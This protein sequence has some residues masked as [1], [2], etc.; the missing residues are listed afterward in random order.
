MI[1]QD[2]AFDAKNGVVLKQ[3]GEPRVGVFHGVAHPSTVDDGAVHQGSLYVR[4]NGELYQKT[5]TA[6]TTW[7]LKSS[8]AGSVDEQ[9]RTSVTDTTTGYLSDK[10]V[11]GTNVTLTTLNPGGNEQIQISSTGGSGGDTTID[12]K[13]VKVQS[14]PDYN[15]NPSPLMLFIDDGSGLYVSNDTQEVMWTIEV[16]QP[17]DHFERVGVDSF[18]DYETPYK[19]Q[20]KYI[21]FLIDECIT[22]GNIFIQINGTTVHT[23]PVSVGNN[24]HIDVDLSIITNNT[25]GDK[26]EFIADSTLEAVDVATTLRLKWVI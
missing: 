22:A 2:R 1:N 17:D 12:G 26:I 5:G 25:A 24:R 9:V 4:T 7:V 23:V 13:N 16:T 15:A 21:E 18:N 10:I 6:N 14:I 19:Y 11:S 8:S 20:L 3:S